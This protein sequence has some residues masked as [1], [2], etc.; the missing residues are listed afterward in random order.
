MILFDIFILSSFIGYFAIYHVTPILYSPLMSVTNAISGIILIGAITSLNYQHSIQNV[1]LLYFAIF[2]AS[3][4][5]F[6]GFYISHKM[7]KMFKPK[8]KTNA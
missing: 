7:L 6:G 2:F 5:I 4:N 3:I 8:E 1:Y